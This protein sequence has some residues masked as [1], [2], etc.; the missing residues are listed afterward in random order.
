MIT[1]VSYPYKT[2]RT[3]KAFAILS[4]YIAMVY[5]LYPTVLHFA[6]IYIYIY[7]IVS[8]YDETYLICLCTITIIIG[9]LP[10]LNPPNPIFKLGLIVWH[11]T[12]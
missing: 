4:R 7:K 10:T 12:A 5:M 8:P 2:I 6:C 1:N 9:S 11:L 3:A